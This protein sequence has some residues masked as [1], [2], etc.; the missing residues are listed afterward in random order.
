MWHFGWITWGWTYHE[1]FPCI[2]QCFAR[3]GTPQWLE[4]GIFVF[5]NI[6]LIVVTAL[7]LRA[8]ITP[9]SDYDRWFIRVNQAFIAG[10]VVWYGFYMGDQIVFRWDLE[11]NHLATGGVTF[12]S[13]LALHILPNR[14]PES[15]T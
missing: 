8:L 3:Y 15:K 9:T 11:E 2:V 7:F 10:L 12:I 14:L 5:V 13:Y 6:S 1:N 4:V